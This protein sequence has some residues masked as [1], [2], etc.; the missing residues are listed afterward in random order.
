MLV[1]RDICLGMRYI[2]EDLSMSSSY[3]ADSAISVLART[4]WTCRERDYP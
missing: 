3:D 4:V 1:D 2:G